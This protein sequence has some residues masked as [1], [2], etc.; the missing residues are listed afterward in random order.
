MT[1]HLFTIWCTEEF[2]P[3]LRKIIQEKK[4]IPVKMLLLL[5]NAPHQSRAQMDMDNEINAFMPANT[6]SINSS[7]EQGVNFPFKS[8][9]LRNKFCN[10]CSCHGEWFF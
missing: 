10:V 2:K 5:N 3:L 9:Y 7:M 4:N 6:M 1:A 8:C